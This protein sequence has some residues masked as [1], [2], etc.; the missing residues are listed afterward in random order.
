MYTVSLGAMKPFPPR[1]NRGTMVNAAAVTAADFKKDR[2]E[3]D[4]E[5]GGVIFFKGMIYFF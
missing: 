5:E 4:V 2:R 3:K 1:T